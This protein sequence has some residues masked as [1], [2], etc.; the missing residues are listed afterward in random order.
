MLLHYTVPRPGGKMLDVRI[1]FG[2]SVTGRF[3][4]G[5]PV[6]YKVYFIGQLCTALTK[7]HVIARGEQRSPDVAIPCKLRVVVVLFWCGSTHAFPHGEGGT[8]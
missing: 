6:P 5:K 3:R 7:I 4:D 2:E 8:A 1:I